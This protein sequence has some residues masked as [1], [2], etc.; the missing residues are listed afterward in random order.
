MTELRDTQ[1]SELVGRRLSS[2]ES[3]SLWIPIAQELNRVGG[4][5]DAAKEYLDAE[6]QRLEERVKNLLAEA[7]S[8]LGR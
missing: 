4:G 8:Q 3:Q 6:R 5:P 2:E 7:K 1:F